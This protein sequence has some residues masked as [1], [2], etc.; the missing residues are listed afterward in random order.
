MQIELNNFRDNDQLPS[1]NNKY[2]MNANAFWF[3]VGLQVFTKYFL[4]IYNVNKGSC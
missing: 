3:G 1:L 2:A 4:L